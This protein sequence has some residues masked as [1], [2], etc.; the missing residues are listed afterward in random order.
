[1][2]ESE[3]RKPRQ[4]RGSARRD[5][6]LDAAAALLIEGGPDAVSMQA[7]AQRAGA[8]TGSM[9][10]FFKDRDQLL[11]GIALRHDNALQV[12]LADGFAVDD[13]VWAER[14][15]DEVIEALFGTAIAYYRRHRDALAT[16]KLIEPIGV[17]RFEQLVARVMALRL[18]AAEG[19]VAAKVLFAVSTGTLH[20]I[21]DAHSAHLDEIATN[22]PNVLT[23]YLKALEAR[24]RA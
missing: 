6:I 1:M 4:A 14:T 23:S 2:A 19:L 9:Y 11:A 20:F 24:K 18:G 8:S 15:A 5:A 12:L 3:L 16:V 13:S 10:H 21:Y 7:V 17:E 22:L